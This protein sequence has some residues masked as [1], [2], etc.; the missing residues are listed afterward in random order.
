MDKQK[1]ILLDQTLLPEREVY[2]ELDNKEDIFE[3]IKM[4]RVR[5]A[6]AIGVAAAYG[7]YVC[8]KNSKAT[9]FKE[10]SD[11][12]QITK[13][14]LATSRPTAVNLFWALD[15]MADRFKK[16][17]GKS[18]DE[19]NKALLQESEDIST[20]DKQMAT[21]IGEHGLT[22]LK[23]NM[24]LLTHCNAGGLV[25]SGIGTALAPMYLGHE[26]GYNFKVYADETRPLL[27]GSRLTAY[28]LHKAGLDVTVICDN[29]A[30]LVM[31]EGKI[32]AVLVGC[33]RVAANGDVANKI[34]TSGVAILAK[35]YGIPMYVLGPTSTIDLNTATGTDID[36]ELRDEQEIANG[37]GRRTAPIG[38][39]AYNPAFDVTDAK[40]ITAIITEKGIVY[41]PYKKNIRKLFKESVSK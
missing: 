6:P 36:I 28:E 40:Y 12:F 5:G 13:D 11:E 35:E 32:D 37:F 20:E 22:L 41:P 29:M 7:L 26:K 1:L 33:D 23:K 17:K 16:E 10:F 14:Y 18:I 24:G 34:G 9:D 39:K 38:V 15:R 2:L 25:A 19:T 27:Q 3:A 31:K 4:L 21:A 30:S 8:M